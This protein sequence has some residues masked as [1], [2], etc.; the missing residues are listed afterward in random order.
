MEFTG[1]IEARKSVRTPNTDHGWDQSRLERISE[2]FEK[3]ASLFNTSHDIQFMYESTLGW[4]A[5]RYFLFTRRHG[6]SSKI[7]Q[8]WQDTSLY[9]ELEAF[10]K[11]YVHR[12]VGRSRT[13]QQA[14]EVQM[15]TTEARF[16]EQPSRG[17]GRAWGDSKL[18]RRNLTANG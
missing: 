9:G 10:Y 1:M 14:W 3:L 7:R 4:Y 5:V 11:I 13:A 18:G 17:L 15:L 8:V 2:F 12:E 16:W 6:Q